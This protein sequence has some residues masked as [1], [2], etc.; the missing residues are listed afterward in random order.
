[1][2]AAA[3]VSP[4]SSSPPPRCT[5]L[6]TKLSKLTSELKEEQEMNKCLRANQLLLQNKLRDEEKLLKETCEQKDLQI[7][8]IQEQ[9]RDVMF[10]LEAQQKINHLP[11]EARQEIQDGQINIPV[12]SSAG[13]SAGGSGRPPSRKGRS[14]RGK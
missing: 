11:A 13:S 3:S 2:A 7:S 9:L 10:Y 8:E 4:F 5:Q 1:M 12:A 6:N 14:K